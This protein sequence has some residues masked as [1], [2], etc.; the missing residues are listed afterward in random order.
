MRIIRALPLAFFLIMIFIMMLTKP[1]DRSPIADTK[2]VKQAMDSIE[3]AEVL[4]FNDSLPVSVAYGRVGIVPD[5]EVP[6]VMFMTASL[7]ISC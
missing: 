1:I 7:F 6:S 2:I 4:T 3:Q 5:P